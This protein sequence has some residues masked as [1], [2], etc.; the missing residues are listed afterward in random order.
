MGALRI[1]SEDYSEGKNWQWD[2]VLALCLFFL[3]M[4]EWHS[5]QN[6]GLFISTNE[7]SIPA[8]LL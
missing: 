1:P 3:C 8:L 4:T 2:E 6:S 5:K 7:D